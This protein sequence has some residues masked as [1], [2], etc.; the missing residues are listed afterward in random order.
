MSSRR[1]SSR[2]VHQATRWGATVL[3]LAGVVSSALEAVRYPGID[4]FAARSVGAAANHGIRADPYS[5][6]GRQAILAAASAEEADTESGWRLRRNRGLIASQI[7]T[8]ISEATLGYRGVETT[9][10][11]LFLASHWPLGFIPYEQA[12]ILFSI[13]S[14]ACFFVG[15][16]V[17][18]RLAGLSWTWALAVLGVLGLT[19]EPHLAQLRVANVNH[20][21]LALV[22][23]F[24]WAASRSSRAGAVWCGLLLA[25]SVL[26]KPNL[27]FLAAGFLPWIRERRLD[28]IRLAAVGVLAGS[29]IV[30]TATIWILPAESWLR[31][32]ESLSQTM[33]IARPVAL[34]NFGLSQ[35]F[36]EFL[37]LDTSIALACMLFAVVLFTGLL[38]HASAFDLVGLGAGAMVLSAP[39]AWAHYYL[40]A[41]PLLLSAL[42]DA[43]KR[44]PAGAVVGMGALLLLSKSGLDVVQDLLG[45]N[46]AVG[47]ALVYNSA[48]ASLY[49]WGVARQWW[50]HSG[51]RHTERSHQVARSATPP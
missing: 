18:G 12:Y 27:A 26:F 32:K 30:L 4:L 44:R 10:T 31:W 33:A 11:P 37:G 49:V 28:R 50:P 43:I 2:L 20:V 46:E 29:V 41:T 9:G 21:Q 6:V 15:G 38:R 17:L 39:L 23:A 48:V 51:V 14:L 13:A 16:L 40:L 3:F 22:A 42:G 25:V 35:V 36:L 47:A 34:G 1:E 5:P 24:L 19:F 45:P 7:V 8:R